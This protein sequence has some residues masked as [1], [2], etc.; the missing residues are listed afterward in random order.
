[1]KNY[2]NIKVIFYSPQDITIHKNYDLVTNAKKKKFKVGKTRLPNQECCKYNISFQQEKGIIFNLNELSKL[3]DKVITIK[4][5]SRKGNF[6]L[7]TLNI[8]NLNADSEFENQKKYL[9][10]LIINLFIISLSVP[11]IVFLLSKI[12]KRREKK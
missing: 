3:L 12:F 11:F 4:V 9:K 6:Y 7:A 2:D 1:M 5:I 8:N 10:K